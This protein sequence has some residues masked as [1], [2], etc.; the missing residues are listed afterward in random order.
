MC[1]LIGN[2]PVFE[3]KSQKFSSRGAAPH[4]A[5]ALPREE[6]EKDPPVISS[7]RNPPTH[8]QEKLQTGFSEPAE[9]QKDHQ[10]K[11]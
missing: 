1:N 4:P 10:P 8:G 11:E 9:N 7:L 5:G 6:F 3:V 2:E